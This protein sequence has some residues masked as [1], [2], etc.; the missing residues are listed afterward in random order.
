[1]FQFLRSFSHECSHCWPCLPSLPS[2]QYRTFGKPFFIF[3]K[4]Q[5]EP[6][7]VL[8][9]FMFIPFS[10]TGNSYQGS[11]GERGKASHLLLSGVW[12]SPA[13]TASCYLL[14]SQVNALLSAESIHAS[15]VPGPGQSKAALWRKREGSWPKSHTHTHVLLWQQP[16][17]R[18]LHF[19]CRSC[20]CSGPTEVSL[21]SNVQICKRHTTADKGQK[22]S[23]LQ[24]V[25]WVIFMN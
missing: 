14:S 18:A 19:A 10:C 20:A 16:N 3:C 9:V 13:S 5:A 6:Q 15:P 21:G 1:M 24:K 11:H 25:K 4:T 22:T 12:S 8:C 2:S 7:M 17:R 23:C